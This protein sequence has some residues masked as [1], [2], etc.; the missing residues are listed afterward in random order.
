MAG[1]LGTRNKQSHKPVQHET[2]ETMDDAMCSMITGINVLI[3]QAVAHEMGTAARILCAAKEEMVHWAVSMNY[4]ET[5]SERFINR[6]TQDAA[7]LA[8][9]EMLAQLSHLG[10]DELR[11]SIMDCMRRNMVSR[12]PSKGCR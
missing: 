5:A 6:H 3:A 8:L 12:K 7:P 1:T 10:D 9:G 2:R 4:H 11:N